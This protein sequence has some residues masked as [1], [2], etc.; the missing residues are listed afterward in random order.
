MQKFK[1][2]IMIS[3]LCLSLLISSLPAFSPMT[4]SA[5]NRVE[6]ESCYLEPLLEW[7]EIPGQAVYDSIF[8][9]IINNGGSRAVVANVANAVR[10]FLEGMLF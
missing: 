2:T 10:E 3:G 7:A 9:A 1:K 8:R 5:Q 6:S 4:N